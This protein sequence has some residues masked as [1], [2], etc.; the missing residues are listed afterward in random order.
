MSVT[1][2]MTTKLNKKNYHLMYNK[3]GVILVLVMVLTLILAIIAFAVLG[4]GLWAYEQATFYQDY[5]QALYSAEAGINY[6]ISKAT[7]GTIPVC[8]SP[9]TGNITNAA[10]YVTSSTYSGPTVMITS[11]STVYRLTA[12]SRAVSILFVPGDNPWK[13]F[14]WQGCGGAPSGADKTYYPPGSN[15][16]SNGPVYG[17]GQIGIIQLSGGKWLPYWTNLMD[18]TVQNAVYI[19]KDTTIINITPT[20]SSPTYRFTT[21]GNSLPSWITSSTGLSI[22]VTNPSTYSI[23]GRYTGML[24]VQGTIN[25]GNPLF[26]YGQLYAIGGNINIDKTDVTVMQVTAT[27]PVSTKVSPTDNAGTSYQKYI[28]IACIDT[29]ANQNCPGTGSP[30]NA[31]A[32]NIN[33][34]TGNS[35]LHMGSQNPYL[36]GG[37]L[38]CSN[39]YAKNGKGTDIN[40]ILMIMGN[41]IN[42]YPSGTYS[43]DN[44]V[45]NDAPILGVDISNI[46]QQS[47]MAGTWQELPY[48]WSL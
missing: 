41:D 1:D 7:T 4:F 21:T 3:S 43:F 40:G 42:G 45:Q 39:L 22:T 11:T 15:Q 23:Y 36:P 20:T 28:T 5:N 10:F 31:G 25:V 48:G 33:Q 38:F 18:S 32:G 19:G 34:S 14:I 16:S 46:T 8:S 13:H 9:S 17:A 44:T 26:I 6:A 35:T 2:K 24:Y 30:A 47:A 27:S 29:S 12:R 37:V